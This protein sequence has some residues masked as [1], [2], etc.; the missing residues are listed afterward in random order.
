[1]QNCAYETQKLLDF[2]AREVGQACMPHTYRMPRFV[3][4]HDKCMDANTVMEIG[5]I[6]KCDPEIDIN[7]ESTRTTRTPS[8]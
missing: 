4:S 7:N 2:D 6:Q 1:M 5:W 3:F 8:Q